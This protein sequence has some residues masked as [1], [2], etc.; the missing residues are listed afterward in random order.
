MRLFVEGVFR[1]IIC[2]EKRFFIC[3][4]MVS[5]RKAIIRLSA[6]ALELV[7]NGKFAGVLGREGKLVNASEITIERFWYIGDIDP[8]GELCVVIEHDDLW[9]VCSGCEIPKTKLVMTHD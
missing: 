1:Y 2:S 7:L 5:M 4:E 6:E 3:L 8:L 9:D